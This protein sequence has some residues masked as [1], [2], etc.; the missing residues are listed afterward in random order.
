MQQLVSINEAAA[1]VGV[2]RRTMERWIAS[3]NLRYVRLGPRTIRLYA[4][5]VA[6]MRRKRKP[7]QST[8][9]RKS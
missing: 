1:Q 6:A 7:R 5:D 2:S 3:G 8:G 4:T 9:K